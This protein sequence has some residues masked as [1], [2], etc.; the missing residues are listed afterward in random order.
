MQR[1]D[2][3]IQFYTFGC[4]VNTY[5]TGLMQKRLLESGYFIDQENPEIHLLNSCAVTQE[6]TREAARQARRIKKKNPEATVV[7]TGCAAQVDGKIL[8]AVPEFD[9][10]VANSHKSELETILEKHFAGELKEKIFRS[11][12]FRNEKLGLGGGEEL[13]HTRSFLKIQDGCNSFCT[14]CIIPYARGKSRSLPVA[15][16]IQ[17]IKQMHSQGLQEVVLTGVHIGDYLDEDSSGG[18]FNLSSLVAQVLDQTEIPRVRLTSLEPIE[19]DDALFKLFQNPRLCPHFH[20]SLQSANSDVLARMKRKYGHQEIEDCL[21]RIKK[22]I[23]HA[24]VGMD[25]IAGFPGE[26]EDHF[27]DTY[28]RLQ[29]LPWTRMHVFPYSER[30]GTRG[31]LLDGSV[32][33]A[34]RKNRA[35]RLREL[36]SERY[37]QE[38]K[39]QVGTIKPVLKLRGGRGEN[40]RGLSR[41]YWDISVDRDSRWDGVSDEAP[42]IMVSITGYDRG[43]QGR[44]NGF[45]KGHISEIQRHSNGDVRV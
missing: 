44:M 7:L 9:L 41:D 19:I 29:S 8:D 24:F 34:E 21:L 17:K 27:L 31:P 43:A 4:K 15:K 12:I 32:P 35:R 3:A 39:A 6:A 40:F 25:V 37:E 36:S 30:E 18:P 22:E 16:L 2:K 13:G 26:T 10:I 23:P 28:R 33:I 14:F 5:D 38:A 1:A 11:N 20:M 45:L 42:E